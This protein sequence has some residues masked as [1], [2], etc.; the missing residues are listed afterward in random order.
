MLRDLRK[1]LREHQRQ[2]DATEPSTTAEALFPS[3]PQRR[4]SPAQPSDVQTAELIAMAERFPR[5][6]A[7]LARL[8][9]QQLLAVLSDD[10][11]ALVRAQVG[12]GKTAVLVH[13]VLW[14]HLVQGVP[15]ERIAVLTFTHKAAG[16]IRTRIEAL[17]A[18]T[19]QLLPATAF[20]L[21]GTFHG[22]ARAL[23][24][25]ALPIDELGWRSDFS[26][27]D[28]NARTTLCQKLIAQHGLTI[29]YQN[30]L[31]QRLEALR[32]G[33]TR[34]GAMKSDDDIRTLHTLLT[35]AKKQQNVLDFADLLD[36]A[37]WLLQEHPLAVPPLRLVVDEFQDCDPRELAFLEALR[38]SQPEMPARFFAVGDPHQVIYAWRG[39]SPQ[40]F[41]VIEQ[42]LGCVRYE[43]PVNYRSTGEILEGA[44]AEDRTGVKT[45]PTNIDQRAAQDEGDEEG[46]D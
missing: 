5:L 12:S 28:E 9:Q 37:T 4:S 26:V 29:R 27:L 38:A 41:D 8:N 30:R 3:R 18:E 20:W 11:A 23:L 42:R 31:S 1:S 13:K 19:G 22:V 32:Q 10:N 35:A 36:A 15:M 16:E 6:H 2:R 34:M 40:L 24:R 33:Q 14:L 45:A 44:R 21:T 25:Q 17:A 46:D 43:L 39:S 7:S